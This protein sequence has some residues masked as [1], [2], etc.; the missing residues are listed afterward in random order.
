MEIW[1]ELFGTF[2]GQLSLI[3]IFIVLIMAGFFTRM[4]IKNS[5]KSEHQSK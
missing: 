3:V 2:E 1:K 4:F 5:S